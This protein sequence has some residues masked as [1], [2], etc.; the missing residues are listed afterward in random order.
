MRWWLR[1]MVMAVVVSGLVGWL[2]GR[3][4]L[5]QERRDVVV[6]GQVYECYVIT[7]VYGLCAPKRSAAGTTREA[8]EPAAAPVMPSESAPICR[9]GRDCD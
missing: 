5:A 3:T 2:G 8:L 1:V 6:D 9:R 7:E 4:A